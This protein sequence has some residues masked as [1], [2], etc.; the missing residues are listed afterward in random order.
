[1]Y[2]LGVDF[3]AESGVKRSAVQITDLYVPDDL[4]GRQVVAV[5]SF[6]P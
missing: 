2:K 6:A 1:M 5:V 4:V 3:G